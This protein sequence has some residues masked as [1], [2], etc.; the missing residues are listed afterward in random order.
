MLRS[1]WR[2]FKEHSFRSNAFPDVLPAASVYHL[3][4][5]KRQYNSTPWQ[6]QP[7][8]SADV[9]A[10]SPPPYA[11]GAAAAGAASGRRPRPDARPRRRARAALSPASAARRCVAH[12]RSSINQPVRQRFCGQVSPQ[13]LGAFVHAMT[14]RRNAFPLRAPSTTWRTPKA[15]PPIHQRFISKPHQRPT[16]EILSSEVP[17]RPRDH[18][19]AIQRAHAT[20]GP[21][22]CQP[23]DCQADRR[24]VAPTPRFNERPAASTAARLRSFG[25]PSSS[26]PASPGSSPD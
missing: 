3:F 1:A 23:A 22:E 7:F 15:N 19:T 13:F 25:P 16:R 8:P 5:P 4:T 9:S 12:T 17:R 26:Q 24:C 18:P 6:P 11:A 21:A 10:S 20:P 14:H 2:I